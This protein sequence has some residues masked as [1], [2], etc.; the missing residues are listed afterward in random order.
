MSQYDPLK[1]AIRPDGSLFDLGWYLGWT[2]GDDEA[3]LDGR[4]S[5]IELRKIADHME[6]NMNNKVEP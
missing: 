2:P 3:V 1:E 4:F 5:I 6:K